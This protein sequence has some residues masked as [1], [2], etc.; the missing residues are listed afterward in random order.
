MPDTSAPHMPQMNRAGAAKRSPGHQG[1]GLWKKAKVV[2]SASASAPSTRVRSDFRM[3]AE[4]VTGTRKRKEKG[5]C[6]P[7]VR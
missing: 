3:V 6:S 1:R 7:P 2:M 5:F 4:M